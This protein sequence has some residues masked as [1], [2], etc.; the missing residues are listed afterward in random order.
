M[1]SNS[2]STHPHNPFTLKKT[3]VQKKLTRPLQIQAEGA[4]RSSEEETNIQHEPVK[5]F[6]FPISEN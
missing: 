6:S 3:S 4:K 2:P 5:E 1:V